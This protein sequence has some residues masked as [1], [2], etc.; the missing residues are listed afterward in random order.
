M[1]YSDNDDDTKHIIVVRCSKAWWALEKERSRFYSRW[2]VGHEDSLYDTV[3]ML[4]NTKRDTRAFHCLAMDHAIRSAH[5]D[6]FDWLWHCTVNEALLSPQHV[7]ARNFFGGLDKSIDEVAFCNLEAVPETAQIRDCFE[8]V[9]LF[10]I[11]PALL[12]DDPRL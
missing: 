11:P 8:E 4:W 1:S 7:D 9:T 5:R 10:K 2:S 12:R 3:V 6:G